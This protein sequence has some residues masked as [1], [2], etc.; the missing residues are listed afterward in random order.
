MDLL[1]VLLVAVVVILTG[2]LSYI[3]LQVILMLRDVRRTLAKVDDV[4]A[5]GGR[6]LMS[7]M[8]PLSNLPNLISALE[9]LRGWVKEVVDGKKGKAGPGLNR[10]EGVVSEAPEHILPIQRRGREVVGRYFRKGGRELAG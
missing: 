9:N 1:Q 8:A 10:G 5:E 7:L 3:G 4:V 6:N 2:L